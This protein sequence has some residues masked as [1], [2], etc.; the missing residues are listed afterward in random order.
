[1]VPRQSVIETERQLA[2]QLVSQ[3]SGDVKASQPHRREDIYQD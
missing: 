1:M 3:S 2:S